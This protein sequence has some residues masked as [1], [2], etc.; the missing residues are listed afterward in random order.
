MILKSFKWGGG[1]LLSH[2]L[3]ALRLGE[4]WFRISLYVNDHNRPLA[5]ILRQR[6]CSLMYDVYLTCIDGDV[7]P[8]TG[9]KY[10]EYNPGSE[11]NI[12]LMNNEQ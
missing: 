5:P 1:G 4:C 6:W 8:E 12:F 11:L 3:L 7:E 10:L 2:P 9:S